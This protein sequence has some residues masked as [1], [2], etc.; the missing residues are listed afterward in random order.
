[1]SSRNVLTVAVEEI[2][3]TTK[4]RGRVL[5]TLVTLCHLISRASPPVYSL[6]VPTMFRI[7]RSSRHLRTFTSSALRADA[8][9][10]KPMLLGTGG[11]SGSVPTDEEQETGLARL[12]LLGKMK[13]IDVF[14]EMPLDA[15]R[16]G[17]I[18]DPIIVP[19]LVSSHHVSTM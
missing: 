13:G 2:A 11:K 9:A 4:H 19:S 12:Q 18:D 7:L 3:N 14:N 8:H 16:T 5:V 10:H 6:R 15:S 17:T 1:M